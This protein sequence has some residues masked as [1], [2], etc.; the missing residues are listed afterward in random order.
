MVKAKMAMVK[1]DERSKGEKRG[2]P[3]HQRETVSFV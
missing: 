1:T 2:R 3:P